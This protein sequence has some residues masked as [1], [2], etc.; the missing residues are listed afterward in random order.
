MKRYITCLNR[1][2]YE[3]RSISVLFDY[4]A[5]QVSQQPELLLLTLPG[6]PK[7][8]VVCACVF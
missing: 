8:A 4:V 3:T 6:K 2:H 7:A 5:E 1:Y